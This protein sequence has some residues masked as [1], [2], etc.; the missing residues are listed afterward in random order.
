MPLFFLYYVVVVVS[1][2]SPMVTHILFLG[3]A[4]IGVCNSVAVIK[5]E[6]DL[7]RAGHLHHVQKIA[8]VSCPVS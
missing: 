3:P 4:N 7:C 2:G 1:D 5:P 8:A 6:E